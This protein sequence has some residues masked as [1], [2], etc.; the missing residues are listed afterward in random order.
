M[1]EKLHN[2]L[3]PNSLILFG[4]IEIEDEKLWREGAE[5]EINKNGGSIWQIL[6]KQIPIIVLFV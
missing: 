1:V 4:Y 3:D 6:W 5:T 2:F